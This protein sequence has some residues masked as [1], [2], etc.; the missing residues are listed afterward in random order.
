MRRDFN[1]LVCHGS[2]WQ[3]FVG[4]AIH[5]QPTPRRFAKQLGRTLPVWGASVHP[6]RRNLRT[7]T[8]MTL[9]FP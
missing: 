6:N 2:L 5:L 9:L 8:F 7:F 1:R 3:V 4:P